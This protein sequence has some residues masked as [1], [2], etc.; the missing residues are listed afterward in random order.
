MIVQGKRLSLE[1]YKRRR[2]TMA[3]ESVTVSSGTSSIPTT[4]A[5]VNVRNRVGD[6]TSRITRSF[7]PSMDSNLVRVAYGVQFSLAYGIF[8]V[9]A[10]V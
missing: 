3:S 2:S 5:P 8:P 1:D 10:S 7:M 6:T 4:A 9:L